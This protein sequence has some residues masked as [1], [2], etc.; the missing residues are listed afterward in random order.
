[1][2]SL[3]VAVPVSGTGPLR[4]RL[5][6]GSAAVFALGILAPSAAAQEACVLIPGS[7]TCL[8]TAA[9]PQFSTGT[10]I[11]PADT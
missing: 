11:V 9:E 2:S 5:L 4:A 6:L 3:I 10:T 8:P 7:V 1:M